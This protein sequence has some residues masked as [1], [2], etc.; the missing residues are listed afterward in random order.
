MQ[1]KMTYE[2]AMERLEQLVQEI[3][4]RTLGVD[5]LIERVKEAQTLLQFCR[6]KLVQVEK[7]IKEILPDED[8]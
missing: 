4:Q 3:E 8:K 1:K 5:H 6:N 7:D 2:Q